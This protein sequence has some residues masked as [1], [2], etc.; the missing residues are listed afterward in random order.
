MFTIS[1]KR[2][3]WLLAV[4][5]VIYPCFVQ[6]QDRAGSL[7]GVVKASS[8]APVSGAFVK[9]KNSERRLTFMVVTQAQGHYGV[10]S[11]P[12]G[13][14][15]V[16]GIGGDFQSE[17]SGP[18]EVATAM[19]MKP[20]PAKMVKKTPTTLSKYRSISPWPCGSSWPRDLTI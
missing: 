15:V 7:Q 11:L 14:Y 16:Q 6:A 3:F 20:N 19:G 2:I 5:A 4:I 10:N 1:Q 8:G 18:V 17:P 12:A 13:K 9:M